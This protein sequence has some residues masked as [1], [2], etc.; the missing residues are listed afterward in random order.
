MSCTRVMRRG[1]Q[2][3]LVGT[4]EAWVGAALSS[5]GRFPLGS[6]GAESP[7]SWNLGREECLRQE[8]TAGMKGH[9]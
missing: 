4:A 7:D 8:E 3:G 5:A 6:S 2:K 9:S 1:T